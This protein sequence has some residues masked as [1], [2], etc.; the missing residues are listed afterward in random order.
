MTLES[1]TNIFA[2]GTIISVN[3]SDKLLHGV[4]FPKNCMR[5]SIDEA[6]EKSTH[7]PYPIPSECELIGEAVGTHVAWPKHLIVKQD[8]LY[9]KLNCQFFLLFIFSNLFT[10]AINRILEGRT[11]KYQER[12]ILC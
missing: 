4:P 2:N 11:L 6:L 7:L 9:F 10:F 3:A 5:V 12:N 8:E 1:S